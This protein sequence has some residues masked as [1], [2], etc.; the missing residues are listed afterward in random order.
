MKVAAAADL[1]RLGTGGRVI[2]AVDD[3]GVRVVVVVRPVVDDAESGGRA[4]EVA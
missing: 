4:E 3:A 1:L 2:V